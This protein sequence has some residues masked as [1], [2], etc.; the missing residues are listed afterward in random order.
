MVSIAAV[1]TSASVFDA[2]G[3]PLFIALSGFALGL[4]AVALLAAVEYGAWALVLPPRPQGGEKSETPTQ[5]ECE[6]ELEARAQSIAVRAD[7]GAR[8]AGLWYPR[9]EV[10]P[11]GKTVILLHG[12]AES[13]RGVQAQRVAVLNQGG[14]NVAAL[15]LRG[16]GSSEGPFAS[17]GGREAGDVRNWIDGL[18]ERVGPG[19]EFLP[20][21]WGRSMGAAIAI[22]A[23]VLDSRVQALILESPMVSLND[24]MGVWF[25]KRRA[26]FPWLLSRL[27]THRAGK[28][29]GVSLTRPRPID[30]AAQVRC[31]VLI[32]HGADDTLVAGRDVRRLAAAFRN[33]ASLVEVPGAGHSDAIAI[34]GQTML[35]QLVQFLKDSLA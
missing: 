14:W 18:A 2:A 10:E 32:V 7:D 22:R 34:G 9:P 30:L 11:T 1:V 29:A 6:A 27:V 31:P 19:R 17:F 8:L 28:L 20:V 13:S 25:R 12:F 24:A 23:A 33:P 5:G 15:D 4:L 26:P 16:Y 3:H 35:R 21:L